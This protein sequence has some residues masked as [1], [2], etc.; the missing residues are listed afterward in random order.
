MVF[1]RIILHPL[2]HLIAGI[3]DVNKQVKE[4]T[5]V[6]ED[7]MNRPQSLVIPMD[8]IDSSPKLGQVPQAG[9]LILAADQDKKLMI[10]HVPKVI[11]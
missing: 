4:L 8:K 9:V 7:Q 3:N 10:I 5:I 2:I 6:W 11:L 1:C